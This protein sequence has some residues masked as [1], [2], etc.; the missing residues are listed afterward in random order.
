MQRTHLSPVHIQFFSY[1]F[2]IML[3]SSMI[4]CYLLIGPHF[5]F[6]NTVS[7]NHMTLTQITC[8]G[9]TWPGYEPYGQLMHS[10]SGNVF[11]VHGERIQK[12]TFKMLLPRCSTL[13]LCQRPRYN[14]IK[15][16]VMLDLML[17]CIVSFR[18]VVFGL[19]MTVLYES[20][21]MLQN[22]HFVCIYT[23]IGWCILDNCIMHY[24]HE[25]KTDK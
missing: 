21:A 18:T 11:K 4:C 14:K 13:N 3:I 2:Q 19:F 12:A 16:P 22:K 1:T 5:F 23:F 24:V 15:M 10:W 20:K 25:A 9:W 6:Y 17:S 8:L 7:L